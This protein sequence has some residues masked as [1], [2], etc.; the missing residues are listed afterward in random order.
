MKGGAGG[1]RGQWRAT[2]SLNS[3]IEHYDIITDA[4]ATANS[5]CLPTKVLI[6]DCCVDTLCVCV[7]LCVC[8]PR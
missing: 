6:V 3:T 4:T 2:I 7:C 1:V 8:D 5:F